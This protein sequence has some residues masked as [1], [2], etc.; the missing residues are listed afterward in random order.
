MLLEVFFFQT[1]MGRRKLRLS[2]LPK[3]FERMC[4]KKSVGR[5]KKKPR[6]T[7]TSTDVSSEHLE[8]ECSTV[9]SLSSESDANT[10]STNVP[11]DTTDYFDSQSNCSSDVTTTHHFESSDLMTAKD[12]QQEIHT[13][14]PLLNLKL[15]SNKWIRQDQNLCKVSDIH[16]KESLAITMCLVINKDMSWNLF[17]HGKEVNTDEC[18]ILKSVPNILSDIHLEELVSTLDKCSLCPG[19]PDYKFVDMVEAKKGKLFSKNGIDVVAMVDSFE[20]VNVDGTTYP[21]TVRNFRCQMIVNVR[22]CQSCVSYRDSL[23]RIFHR[24]SKQKLKSP[25][26][27]SSKS[28]G[29]IRYLNT[30]EKFARYSDFRSRYHAQSKEVERLRERIVQMTEKNHVVLDS[31]MSSDIVQLMEGMT[32][33]VHQK[34][35]EGSF[36]RVFWDQQLKSARVKDLRQIR[37]HPAVIKWC[38][39]LKFI[40]SACYH[41]LRG[42]GLISL[43]SERTLRDYTNWIRPGIGFVPEVDAQLIKEARVSEEKDKFVVLIWDEMKICEDLVFN[44]HTCELIGFLNIGEVNAQ[45]DKV[46]E[47]LHSNSSGKDIASH[48]LLF[49]IRGMFS[50]LEFPYA[51]F[52][53]RGITA[54]SLFPLVWEA[55]R[56][57]ECCGL[58]VIAFCCDGA[59]TNRKFYKMHDRGNGVVNKTTNPFQ[60]ERDIFFICDIPH[61]IKTTR[62]CWSNS[63]ANKNSRALWVTK[64]FR[65][66]YMSFTI[67]CISD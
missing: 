54:D 10:S 66:K 45:L 36:K 51:H 22:K 1:V 52:A 59:S 62:N 56:H 17:V 58:H 6:I 47:D 41:A 28:K 26:R 57:L 35:P 37:W 60:P 13:L 61:L 20:P 25:I 67:P 3:S 21:K 63:F 55:V 38:L 7:G 44:K 65:R 39:H 32:E 48:M 46:S 19:N 40:S 53:T 34:C 24:W 42:S 14:A 16:S 9:S 49:M 50:N 4:P 15:P 2:R 23:R 30:P 18:D 64:T 31:S 8:N 5:P 11:S 43:P 33:S 29:N 12:V 27:K